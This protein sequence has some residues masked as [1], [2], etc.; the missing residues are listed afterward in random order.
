MGGQS[1]IRGYL[2]QT[3]IAVLESLENDDWQSVSIEPNDEHEKVDIKWTYNDGSKSVYQVK[4]SQNPFSLSDAKKWCKELNS[5]TPNAKSYTLSLVG[6]LADKLFEQKEHLGLNIQN[7]ELNFDSLNAEAL[8][9]IERFYTNRGKDKI[10]FEVKD[11]LVNNLILHLEKS[12]IVGIEMQKD[13]FDTQLLKWI[14]DIE[15]MVQKNPFAQFVPP[16]TYLPKDK[17]HEMVRNIL[18]FIGWDKLS[19]SETLVEV[20]EESGEERIFKVDFSQSWESTLKDN[21]I[22]HVFISSIIDNQY[23]ENPKIQLGEYLQCTNKIVESLKNKT[24]LTSKELEIYNILFWLSLD[25]QQV[26]S[27]YNYNAKNFYKSNELESSSSFILIDNAR[28]NFLI[29]SII[30]AKNYNEF[31]VK[32]L[33]PITEENSSPQKIGKRGYRLPAQYINSPVLPIIK[34]SEEKISILLFCND[35][36]S[37]ENL[38]KIIWLIVRLTSGFGNEYII[39]FP[40][41]KVEYQNEVN[42]ILASFNDDLLLRKVQVKALPIIEYSELKELPQIEGTPKN[43]STYDEDKDKLSVHINEA[44]LYQLPYGDIIKPFL[45]T[46]LVNSND[47]KVFLGHRGLF[48]KSGDKK[49][50]MNLMTSL[51]FSPSE[52]KNLIR[53]I[54]KK[55]RPSPSVPTIIKTACKISVSEVFKICKPNFSGINEGINSRLLDQIE[56][57]QSKDNPNAFVFESYVEV[58]DPTKQISVNTQCYPI[59]V[60]CVNE[61]DNLIITNMEA[62]CRDGKTIG[63]RIVKEIEKEM[64]A[65]K[66]SL[67]ESIKIKF[68]SLKDNTE[69][70]NFLLSFTRIDDSNLFIDQDIKSVKYIFDES[71]KIPLGY[72]DKSDKDIVFILRGRKLSGINE[73][74]ELEFKESI[75][76]EEIDIN[77]KFNFRGIVGFYS[78]KYNFSNALKNK[79]LINGEFRSEPFLH[80]TPILKKK[81]KDSRLLENELKSEIEKIKINRFKQFNLI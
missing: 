44:F 2:I 58:K 68:D 31:P 81:V 7:K 14:S 43:D 1:A 33:Y 21:E 34:E 16:E 62:N 29:S 38:K 13:A 22:D 76:L 63:R 49:R 6:R 41:Y 53:F 75:F 64:L 70:V 20:D 17:N 27:D 50:I 57:K 46:D 55:D 32:F 45:K 37:E 35:E 26:N 9:L 54:N 52:L 8:F 23:P 79:E 3:I 61:G 10:T 24:V 5:S 11:I 47:L 48:L 72:Q 42:K 18:K 40:D 77:Y 66:I 39:Y 71:Q 4:S 65:K 60:T 30:A 19:E 12:S 59:K 80:N 74:S 28:L 25:N 73:M 15:R 36:Y 78:V 67:S 69:R 56:F 51:L